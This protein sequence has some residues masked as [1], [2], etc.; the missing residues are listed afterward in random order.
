MLIQKFF[1]VWHLWEW[2]IPVLL[3]M[4]TDYDHAQSLGMTHQVW[5]TKYN[6]QDRLHLMPVI[7]P[8]YPQQNSTH[9]VTRS[10]LWVMR[11]EFKLGLDRVNKILKTCKTDPSKAL[12]TSPE[13]NIWQPLFQESTFFY[14]YDKF[15]VVTV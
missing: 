8:A 7:T 3:K 4:P 11:Q 2:P 12:T 6:L 14:D 9:N 10:T 5:D 15:L 1:K 13:Q